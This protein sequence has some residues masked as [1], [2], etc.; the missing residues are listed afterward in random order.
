VASR[1]GLRQDSFECILFVVSDEGMSAV[2]VGGDE[3]F[4]PL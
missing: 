1:R 4:P 3:N 2:L